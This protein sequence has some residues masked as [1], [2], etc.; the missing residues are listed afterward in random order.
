MKQLWSRLH[1]L[2]SDKANTLLL[3]LSCVLVL[4]PHAAHLPPWISAVLGATLLWRASITLRGKRLPRSRMLLPVA[5]LAMAGVYLSFRTLLGRDAGVA[6]LALLLAFKLLEMH[7]R[8]DLFVVVFLGFFLLL[9]NFF[10]SQTIL[11]GIVMAS[12]VIALLTAQLSFQYTG[13]LPSLGRRL[14]LVCAMFAFAA[15]LALLLF[16]AFPRIQG[17]LWGLPGDSGQA[18]SGLSDS[19]APGNIAN[20]ALSDDPAFR[21]RFK[22][23][24]PAQNQLYWRGVVLGDYDGRTWT[25]SGAGKAFRRGQRIEQGKI[26]IALNSAPVD[27]QVTL[28]ASGKRWIFALDV[29]RQIDRL[30]GNPYA[31]SPALEVL[32]VNNIEQ[33]VRYT[34]SSVLDYRLQAGESPDH[35][36]QWLEL[37][38][39]FNP[40]SLA[41]ARAIR[42]GKQPEAAIAAVLQWFRDDQFSYTLQ[43]PQLGRNAVDEFLFDSKAGFCEHYAGAFVVLMRAMGM[44]ARVVT[45]YQ[46]GEANPVDGYLT[47]RQSDAHAWAEV[48]LAGRGWLRIDPTAAVAPER[49]EHNLARALPQRAPFGLQGLSDLIAYRGGQNS[50]L[51]ALRFNWNAVNNAWNQWVLDYNPERQRGLLGTLND[52]FG[53]W[54]S[55]LGGLAIAAL[56]YI[57]W[58]LEQRRRQDPLE[59][60]YRRFCRQQARRGYSRAPH[61]GPHSYAMRLAGA[62]D[63]SGTPQQRQAAA[64]FLALYGQLRY[65]PASAE[66]TLAT[67]ARLRRL[68]SSC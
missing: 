29:P 15:P 25:R 44:P 52:A 31:V 57:S 4:A 63:T 59:H 65:G 11:T 58:L 62:P 54:Q 56:L 38:Q 35:L 64:D 2:P 61:E 37:P 13:A 47:V 28:E 16:V 32:V 30:Q 12:T 18:R 34:A 40:R 41:R 6:M 49:I 27:Y 67:I 9:T 45:G 53:N 20:L 36:Q 22:Q 5:L 55:L 46:G 51:N 21:V 50:W 48:W 3:L 19:M 39:G 17:P 8:R 42:S 10:Y 26:E 14:R 24:V 66:S 1:T 68:L 33:R 43:P 7:A 60:L 23:A